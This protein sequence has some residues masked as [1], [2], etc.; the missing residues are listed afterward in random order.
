MATN[1]FTLQQ[2]ATNFLGTLTD[3]ERASLASQL[4]LM[5]SVST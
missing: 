2:S 3:A 4:F 1:N 5:V